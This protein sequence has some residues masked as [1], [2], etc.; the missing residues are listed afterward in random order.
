[1]TYKILQIDGGGIRGIIPSVICAA[2]EERKGEPISRLFDMISGTST[3]AILGGALAAGIPAARVRDL[4]L[5]EGPALF[6]PRFFLNPKRWTEGKYDR[7]KFRERFGT[8]IGDVNIGE[9]LTR[10]VATTFNLSSGRTHFVNSVDPK[11]AG[12]RLLDVISWSALSAANYFGKINAPEFAWDH[13]APDGTVDAT[14]TG[15]TFQDGG[16]GINNCTLNNDMSEVLARD[17]DDVLILSLGCGS[18]DLYVPYE[19]TSKKGFV[20]QVFAYFSQARNEST[21]NQVLAAKYVEKHRPGIRTFRLDA[22]I[23]AKMDRLDAVKYADEFRRVGESL[24]PRVPFD[25]L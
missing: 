3:G 23:P 9:V 10:Y 16:Q 20:A 25:L 11:D 1:M 14:R 7:G 24:V 21:I 12:Y 13:Y 5:A 19:K 6:N 8:V 22:F 17:H 15:A 2:I 4:Y 18:S